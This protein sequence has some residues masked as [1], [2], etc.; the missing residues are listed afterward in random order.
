MAGAKGFNEIG[1][2]G[3]QRD[4]CMLPSMEPE[5]DG[6]PSK[7]GAAQRVGSVY[8]ESHLREATN[9]APLLGKSSKISTVMLA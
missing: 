7:S 8:N 9:R 2:A 5:K 4:T 1:S 3:S 6:S